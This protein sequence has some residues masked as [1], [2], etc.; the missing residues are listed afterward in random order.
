MNAVLFVQ[1]A[2][3][4]AGAQTCLVRLISQPRAR[5]WRPLVLCSSPGWLPDEC[6]RRGIPCLIEPFPRSRSVTSRLFSNANFTKTVKQ[7]L[8]QLAIKPVI[9]H[10]NDHWEGILG[11]QLANALSARSAVFLRTSRLTEE[12]YYKYRCNRY[13]MIASVGPTLQARVSQWEKTKEVAVYYD[14]VEESDFLPPRQKSESPPRR[15]LVIGA[16]RSSKGWADLVEALVIQFKCGRWLPEQVDFTGDAPAKSENNLNLQ[17]VSQVRF[18]FLGHVE[19]FR[20]L[21]RQY[22]LVINPSR[23]DSFGMAAVETLAAGVPL[24]SSRTGVLEQ[25]IGQEH[26]LFAPS[27]PESLAGA[28]NNVIARW[29]ELDFGVQAAQETISQRFSI[30]QSID[31]VDKLYRQLGAKFADSK[32]DA[33]TLSNAGGSGCCSA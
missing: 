12:Q 19:R 4:R 24:L 23:N 29:A 10:A 17:R 5:L 13:D 7:R 1:N 33:T 25:I 27:A 26:M 15:L 22:E 6:N 20:E 28:L 8:E 9:V 31:T 3:H 11:I 21:V 18:H 16:P 2:T 14:G 30:N 32:L